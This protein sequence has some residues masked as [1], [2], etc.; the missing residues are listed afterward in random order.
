[1]LKLKISYKGRNLNTKGNVMKKLLLFSLVMAFVLGSLA[2]ATDT[3]VETMGMGNLNYFYDQSTVTNSVLK[4]DAN[5]WLYPSTINNYP[6]LFAAEIT[7]NTYYYSKDV[8]SD[9]PLFKVGANLQGG[10]EDAP[11]VIG[12]YFSTVPYYHYLAPFDPPGDYFFNERNQ[13]IDLFY[14]RNLGDIPF[15]INFQFYNSGYKN[16]DADETD[17]YEQSLSRYELSLGISPMEGK[18]DLAVGVA[19]TTWTDKDYQG[20]PAAIVDLTEPDGNMAFFARGRYWM[21]PMDKFTFVPHFTFMYDK[22]GRKDNYYDGSAWTLEYTV[23]DK[24]TTIDLGLGMNY[25]ASEDVLVAGDFGFAFVTDKYEY[26]DAETADNNW[27]DKTTVMGLPYFRLGLD[28]YVFKWL[29][30]R[31]GVASIWLRDKYEY[32]ENDNADAAEKRTTSVPHTETFLGAGFH[33]GN[34]MIDAS[35]DPSFLTNGPYFLTGDNTNDMYNGWSS[36]V[37]VLYNF[38]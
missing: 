28:A 8:Y 24:M 37:S 29:D 14:G 27:N 35:I 5:I 26:V 34:L 3:R 19:M 2:F 20:G 7:A 1:M 13:R 30:V 17:N 38:D 12:A 23:S 32:E 33:W 36:R 9:L 25:D 6:N 18:A 16:E 10:G 11:F 31:C 4:D 22:H 21:D 15:G